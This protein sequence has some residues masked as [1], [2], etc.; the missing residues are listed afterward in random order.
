[1]IAA[2]DVTK[3]TACRN[4]TKTCQAETAF[5]SVGH[6]RDENEE[7]DAVPDEILQ[8][9]LLLPVVG[10]V[11]AVDEDLVPH[12]ATRLLRGNF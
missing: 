2:L 11:S 8:N 6:H 7:E 3:F 4:S 10:D 12:A 9:P 5:T 1:M